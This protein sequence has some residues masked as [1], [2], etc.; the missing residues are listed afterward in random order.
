MTYDDY[1]ALEVSVLRTAPVEITE[2]QFY[3][4]L[5]VLPPLQWVVLGGAETFAMSE[6]YTGRMTSMYCAIN[7]KYYQ[8]IDHIKQH[9]KIVE[10]VLLSLK[11]K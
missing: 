11:G 4:A 5:E 1:K 10:A 7:G 8:I 3:R 9:S 2:E 6:F